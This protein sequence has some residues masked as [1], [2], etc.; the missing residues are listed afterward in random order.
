ME[1]GLEKNYISIIS[2]TRAEYAGLF[3]LQQFIE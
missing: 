3:T 1:K 2:K